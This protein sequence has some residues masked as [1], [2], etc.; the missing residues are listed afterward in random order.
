MIK[1]SQINL[2]YG[3]ALSNYDK[4]PY[5][6]FQHVSLGYKGNKLLA[7]GTN[8]LKTHTKLIQYNYHNYALVHSELDL[9]IQLVNQGVELKDINCINFCFSNI[10]L[11]NK[12]VRVRTSKPCQYC[13][14]WVFD[15]FNSVSFYFNNQWHTI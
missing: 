9:M 2:A 1:N 14:T 10:S 8:K 13:S 11:R 4:A 7:I 15:T 6:K 3:Y 12:N 5:R